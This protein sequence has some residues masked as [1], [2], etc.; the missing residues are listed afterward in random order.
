V[1][2]HTKNH[3][4]HA[5]KKGIAMSNVNMMLY[6]ARKKSVAV[7]YLFWFFF[8]WLG[9]HRF[10]LGSIKMGL[11]ELFIIPILFFGCHA[12]GISLGSTLFSVLMFA[13]IGWVIVFL[14]VFFIP[15]IAR[16]HNTRLA[17]SLA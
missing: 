6:D 3:D 8:G 12:L 1:P 4:R 14:D 17:E 5:K 11:L 9:V 15:G 16:R 2:D 7:A 13:A 10:Y